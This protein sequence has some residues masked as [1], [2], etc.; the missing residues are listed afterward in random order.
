MLRVR[1]SGA[2][3]SPIRVDAAM[4]SSGIARSIAGGAVAGLF[5]S[6]VMDRFQ[7]AW[8]AHSSKVE[9]G[10]GG[11]QEAVTVQVAD[12]IC[13]AVTGRPVPEALRARAGGAVHYGLGGTLGAA[14]GCAAHIVPSVTAGSGSAYSAAVWLGLDEGLLPILG[15]GGKWAEVPLHRHVYGFVSHIVFG[16]A[17]EGGRRLASTGRSAALRLAAAALVAASIGLAGCGTLPANSGAVDSLTL[18]VDPG[19]PLVTIAKRSTP[20][21]EHSGVRLMPLDAFSL[22][23]RVQLTQRAT[24]SL[25]VQYYVLANDATGRLLMAGLRDAAARGV[26]VRVLVDDLYTTDTDAL[27]RGLAAFPNVEVRLFNP[28]CCARGSGVAGRYAASLFDFGRLNHRMHNKLFIADGVMA[29]AGGRNIADEYFLRNARFNFVDV[30]AFVLGAIVIELSAIFDRY[31]NSEVVFPIDAVG[32]PSADKPAR[33]RAFDATLASLPV[34]S[35]IDLPAND[36]L[37]YGPLGEK[38]DA[39]QVGL[40]WGQARAFADPP[41]KQLAQT[42]KIAFETSVVKEVMDKVWRARSEL[43]ITP[44]YIISGEQGLTSLRSLQRDNVK[45]VFVT[46]SL[47]ATDEPLVHNGYSKYRPGMLDA[48]VD[49]YELSP[50]LTQQA[51]RLGIF[52]ASLGRLHAKT[53]VIDRHLVFIGSMNLDPRSAGANTELGMFI[54]SPALAKELLR[55][56]DISKLEG[57]YRVRREP[58]GAALQWLTLDPES[59]EVI[60]RGEPESS[61]W[62]RLRNRLLGWFVPEQLL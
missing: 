30:D 20:A 8:A 9:P 11:E 58:G 10:P 43:V 36:V 29:V 14:Y 34:A 15:L 35:A 5:A 45:V 46:N 49:L 3:H 25:D 18:P 55:V 26:R 54:D 42:P 57:A 39:G 21:D 31:W 7:D 56:I 6:F 1:I 38:F 59:D 12:K 52:G 19:S 62:P 17:L 23:T 37:G 28:F 4:S 16:L 44:P 32:A 22:D 24:V 61:F 27:L 41:E 40:V 33:Q 51:E 50:T 48:G 60:A 2:D 13:Q 47:A 53:A